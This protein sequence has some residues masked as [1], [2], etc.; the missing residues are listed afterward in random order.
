[1]SFSTFT[2]PE[3]SPM[4]KLWSNKLPRFNG[5]RA[6]AKELNVAAIKAASDLPTDDEKNRFAMNL[7]ENYYPHGCNQHRIAAMATR[8]VAL[9]M[10]KFARENPL[11]PPAPQV[12][13]TS[14]G[15][16]APPLP[17][18]MIAD[19]MARSVPMTP[20]MQR[21]SPY[22]PGAPMMGAGG[23]YSFSPPPPM[24]PLT[25]AFLYPTT[26]PTMAPP[27][28]PWAPQRVP[29]FQPTQDHI[30]GAFA[31]VA[32][33]SLIMSSAPPTF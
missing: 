18:S 33:L 1:M 30:D 27:S 28:L 22:P 31:A 3:S 2:H 10:I 11:A 17:A 32:A 4:G 25:D 23:P 6:A 16:G 9:Y 29:G 7:I 12:A 26:P 24:M 13:A 15:A 21:S 14:G 19:M 8:E 20:P 5:S